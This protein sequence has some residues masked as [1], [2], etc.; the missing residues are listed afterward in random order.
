MIQKLT[1]NIIEKAYGYMAL[2]RKLCSKFSYNK[3]KGFFFKFEQHL[4]KLATK[5]NILEKIVHST[6]SRNLSSLHFFVIV[7]TIYGEKDRKFVL[8]V[9]FILRQTL[10]VN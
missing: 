5:R 4:E 6:P 10:T 9:I 8:H 2:L 7:L 1:S 3:C